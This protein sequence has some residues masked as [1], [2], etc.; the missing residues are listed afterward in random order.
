MKV[1]DPYLTPPAVESVSEQR[2]REEGER[3]TDNTTTP[4]SAA[5]L[6]ANFIFDTP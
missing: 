1:R 3:W 5:E 4:L 2:V 6:V